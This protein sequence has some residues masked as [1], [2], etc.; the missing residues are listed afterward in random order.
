[1]IAIRKFSYL[2][3]IA[4][5][6]LLVGCGS[7]DDDVSGNPGT[8]PS[9]DP[10]VADV[11]LEQ[12]AGTWFGTFDDTSSVRTFEFTVDEAGVMSAIRLEGSP[13]NLSG[14]ITKA[15]EVGRAFRFSVASNGNEIANGMMMVDPA[16]TYMLYVDRHASFG[17]LQKGAT[18][19]PDYALGDI[20]ASWTGDAVTTPTGFGTLSQTPTSAQCAPTDPA[21][22][23]PTSR[24]S[25]TVGG[26]ERVVSNLRM[27]HDRGRFIGSF[28]DDPQAPPGARAVMRAYLSPDKNFA[29]VWACDDFVEFGRDK[30]TEN[31]DFSAWTRQ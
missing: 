4:S 30:Q 26:T 16:G 1:M 14:S 18:E 3:L 22:D 23:P 28:T 27:D 24:C 7:D 6:G 12:L 17:A 29:A 19:L 11:S 8:N 10:P 15:T 25:V 9:D 5:F 20:D 31:C 2:L 21:T 13:T